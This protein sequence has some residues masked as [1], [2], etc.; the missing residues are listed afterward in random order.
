M[1]AAVSGVA[2]ET[3]LFPGMPFGWFDAEQINL[4]DATAFGNWPNLGSEGDAGWVSMMPEFFRMGGP[5]DGNDK[6]VFFDNATAPAHYMQ[7]PQITPQKSQNPNGGLVIGVVLL[8]NV[9]TSFN[10]ITD[11]DSTL[12]G[13]TRAWKVQGVGAGSGN[14]RIDA[15]TV[16]NDGSSFGTSWGWFVSEFNGAGSRIRT[17][18]GVDVTGDAG[19][20]ACNRIR[21]AAN[22]DPGGGAIMEG[23]IAL[24]GHY[25]DGTTGDTLVSY[26]TSRYP[27]L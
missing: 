18:L 26:L 17:N 19:N 3:S 14:L 20:D 6:R 16:L 9:T 21:I 12:P 8:P 4:P 22:E 5:G 24:L 2:G 10:T 13:P 7:T 27:S 11:G 25:N 15:G 1:L 23:S